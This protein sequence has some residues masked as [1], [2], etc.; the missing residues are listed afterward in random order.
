MISYNKA[1]Q[2]VFCYTVQD[3]PQCAGCVRDVVSFYKSET[4][5][6]VQIHQFIVHIVCSCPSSDIDVISGVLFERSFAIHFFC[7]RLLRE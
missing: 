7:G 6:I 1:T 2:S 3:C 4:I 5:G